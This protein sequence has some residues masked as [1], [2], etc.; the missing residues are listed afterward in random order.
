MHALCVSAAAPMPPIGYCANSSSR[1]VNMV[2]ST[3]PSRPALVLIANDQEWMA[4]SLESILGPHGFA[5]LRAFTGRQC[6]DLARAT[7][8]DAVIVDLHQPDMGGLEVLH[9]LRELPSGDLTPCIAISSEAISRS[10]RLA[11]MEAGAWIVCTQPLDGDILLHQLSTF[12][13]SRRAMESLTEAHLLDADSGFYNTRGLARR[14]RELGAEAQRRREPLAC[15]AITPEPS[16]PG[17]V[18]SADTPDELLRRLLDVLGRSGRLSDV[19]GRIG[20]SEFALLLPATE[21]HGAVRLVERLQHALAESDANAGGV[22]A[23][24]TLLRAGYAAVADF[25]DS[26]VDAVELVLRA[27]AAMRHTRV[28]KPARMITAFDEMP[29]AYLH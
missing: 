14:A 27:A 8:P 17:A 18:P 19:V 9:A 13:R 2:D 20:Q 29:A 4:R 28:S 10:Q 24:G 12:V 3:P 23:G 16:L 25:A 22:G 6:I 5:V 7:Q 1:T 15:V 11:A 26:P 21:A